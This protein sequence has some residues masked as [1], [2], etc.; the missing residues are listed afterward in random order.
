MDLK[1]AADEARSH[2]YAPYSGFRVGS[3]IA[4]TDGRVFVGANVENAA[5]GVGMCAERTAIGSAVSAGASDFSAIA[6]T[7]DSAE[8]VPPCGACRQVM[9]E[10]A[11]SLRV[12]S[13]GNGGRVAEWN[14]DELLP[15]QFRLDESNGN[16]E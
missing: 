9:A 5:Y 14:L 11:P 15:H 1:K 12:I 4:T 8:P 3:A 10:F 2:A 7:S 6:I 16:T 13:Y